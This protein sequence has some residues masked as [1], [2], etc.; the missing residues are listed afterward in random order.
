MSND[1]AR[2]IEVN[3][4]IILLR[5][6]V[7]QARICVISKLVREAKK[8][9]ALRGNE[10][11]LERNKNKADKL[12]KE[13]FALKDIKDD[14]ISK[15]GIINSDNLQDMLENP[16]T[17][18]GT[19]AM[20][21]IARYKHLN[22]KILKFKE[23]F[24]DYREFVR[25]RKNRDSTKRKG[26]SNSVGNIPKANRLRNDTNTVGVAAYKEKRKK[27]EKRDTRTV[28]EANHFERA[29]FPQ[30]END[31]DNDNGQASNELSD[32]SLPLRKKL[33][34]KESKLVV[35][36]ISKEAA[37]KRFVEV[38]GETDTKEESNEREE[39]DVRRSSNDAV[40]RSKRIDDFFL[41]FDEAGSN[42]AVSF[43]EGNDNRRVSELDPRAFEAVRVKSKD[44]KFYKDNRER[45]ENGR[46][47][48][49]DGNND[50]SRGPSTKNVTRSDEKEDTRFQRTSRFPKRNIENTIETKDENLHPSWAARKKQ[51]EMMKQAFQG[52][53]IKFDEY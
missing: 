42:D 47:A 13:V 41:S 43:V 14:E 9:R 30:N 1:K 24:P 12:L 31:D 45:R 22:E 17:D 51:Q 11:Q 27:R 32:E 19:K 10:K 36:V 53:K 52:K 40:E 2:Q 3:N 7:R 25:Q 20:I 26:R 39:K 50:I 33:E 44:G 21:K 18:D 4:E 5:Q 15:F 46:K 23:K 34:G 6:F 48:W 16:G 28:T 29:V 8:L 49:T 37:V 35:K 38:L